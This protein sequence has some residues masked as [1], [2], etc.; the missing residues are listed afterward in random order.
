[1]SVSE[2]LKLLVNFEGSQTK[3]SQKT[4]L[5]YSAIGKTLKRGTGLTAS[6]LEQ[7]AAAYPTLNLRWLLLGED[8]MWLDGQAEAPT[9]SSPAPEL[10][11]ERMASLLDK[12]VKELERELKR[13]DPEEAKRLGIE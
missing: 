1:M 2:R 7:I 12:R 3:F 11:Y 9:K 5:S 6:S 4:G 8:P 13:I 10:T